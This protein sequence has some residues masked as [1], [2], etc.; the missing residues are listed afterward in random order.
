[1]D[2]KISADHDRHIFPGLQHDR[3][4]VQLAIPDEEL[5]DRVRKAIQDAA[6]RDAESMKRLRLAIASFTVAL[7]DIGTTPEHV[8]IALK[9][10][11]NNRSLVAVAPHDSDWSGESLREKIST[12]CIEEFFK[13]AAD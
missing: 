2:D 6:E 13:E 11:I 4:E 12:W 9:T 1:M 8:L 3:R 7:R 10:V 5:G